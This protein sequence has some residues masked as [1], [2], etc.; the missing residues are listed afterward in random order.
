MLV[1]LVY[2][3]KFTIVHTGPLFFLSSLPLLLLFEKKTH[4]VGNELT[5]QLTLVRGILQCVCLCLSWECHKKPK[6]WLFLNDSRYFIYLRYLLKIL[7]W[8]GGDTWVLISRCNGTA[9]VVKQIFN[10]PH[11]LSVENGTINCQR[12]RRGMGNG[13]GES[14]WTLSVCGTLAP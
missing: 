12:G 3:L 9:W 14:S 10:W 8:G 1:L 11:K 5:S 4:A 6:L 2:Y 7:S 13:G